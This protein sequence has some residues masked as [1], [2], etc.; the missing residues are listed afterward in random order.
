[1]QVKWSDFVVWHCSD[2]WRYAFEDIP[3]LWAL[4]LRFHSTRE[5]A[6]NHG[7]FQKRIAVRHCLQFASFSRVGEGIDVLKATLDIYR[8]QQYICRGRLEVIFNRLEVPS[9]AQQLIGWRGP[10]R[11][12][13]AP[14]SGP[15]TANP[16]QLLICHQNENRLPWNGPFEKCILGKFL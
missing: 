6:R 3:Y 15:I 16:T 13:Q 8:C 9:V 14:S 10:V 11:F 5:K 7:C 1:M 12:V 4:S 2:G